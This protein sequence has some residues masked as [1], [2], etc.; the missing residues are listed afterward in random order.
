MIRLAFLILLG[1]PNVVFGQVDVTFVG[2]SS[3]YESSWDGKLLAFEKVE[4]GCFGY[5]EF[6]IEVTTPVSVTYFSSLFCEDRS[7]AVDPPFDS[8]S[9][10]RND[11]AVLG[12]P[13]TWFGNFTVNP[14]TYT[15]WFINFDGRLCFDCCGGDFNEDDTVDFNDLQVLLSAW[16]TSDAG[17]ANYDGMTDFADLLIV[18]SN[19][20]AC[21]N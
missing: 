11:W 8:F 18:T 1:L 19:W 2:S 16:D 5:A 14:G 12:S 20:G 7:P 17:D 6:R 10:I 3:P 13:S 21:A 15:D 4:D 9:N